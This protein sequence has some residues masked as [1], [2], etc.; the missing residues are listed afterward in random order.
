MGREIRRVPPNWQHPKQDCRH[1][2]PC[3][4]CYQPM[5]DRNFE[6][7]AR[8]WVKEMIAWENGT[9]KYLIEDPSRKKESPFYWMWEGPPPE[10]EYHVPY[11]KE[12]ATWYQLYETVTEGTP[13]SPPFA[14]KEELGNYLMTYGD[15]WDRKSGRGGWSKAMVENFLKDEWAPSF[16]ATVGPQGATIQSGVEALSNAKQENKKP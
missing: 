5:H 10:K 13:V 3:G 2:P 9:H 15:D 14:T 12:E 4:T 7:A 6:E 8:E 1:Y 11:T 16:V